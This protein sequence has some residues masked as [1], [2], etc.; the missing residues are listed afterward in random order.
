MSQKNPPGN[1][2]GHL[3]LYTDVNFGGESKTFVDSDICLKMSWGSKPIKSVVIEGNPWN[4]YQEENMKV[5]Y[6]YGYALAIQS[7]SEAISSPRLRLVGRQRRVKFSLSSWHMP[8]FKM[9]K[10]L[11]LK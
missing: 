9:S 10:L 7:C 6:S 3:T 2:E 8:E 11:R 5:N 1:G 4:F